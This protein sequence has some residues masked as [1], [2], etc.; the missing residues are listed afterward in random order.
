VVRLTRNDGDAGGRLGRRAQLVLA[1]AAVVAL[2]M[3]PVVFAYLQLGYQADVRAAAAD[4]DPLADAERTLARATHE[5]GVAATRGDH[6]W[7]NRSRAVVATRRSLEPRLRTV[8]RSRVDDGVAYRIRYNA[9]A[10]VATARQACPGGPDRQFGA[11]RARGGVVVQPRNGRTHVLAVAFDVRVVTPDRRARA[12]FV[13]PVVD[14][15]LR[16]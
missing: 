10:A 16:R 4:G 11:C 6:D 7:L 12:T 2:A 14:G 9:S 13:L 1:A 8:E 5:A 15:T 3:A